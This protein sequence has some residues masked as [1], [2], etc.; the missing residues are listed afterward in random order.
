[1]TDLNPAPKGYPIKLVRDNTP[2]IINASGEPGALFY[3][4]IPREER[5]RWLGRKLI[6]EVAEYL[7]SG[8]IDELVDIFSVVEGLAKT[9]GLTLYDLHNLALND[10]R[11]GFLNGVMMRGL[12]PEYDSH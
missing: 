9:H 3:D 1:M 2:Q 7:E 10:P 6:E 11:G 5:G 4:R 12:H 8:M